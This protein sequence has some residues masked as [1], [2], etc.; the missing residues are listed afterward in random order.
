MTATV[1]TALQG[2]S[3]PG[4]PRVYV[5]GS[6]ERRVTVYAQQVRALN[7]VYALQAC[8]RLTS[9]SRVAVV[10]AGAAGLMC[11]A[12]ALHSGAQVTLLEKCK[13][14][15]PLFRMA[16]PEKPV[17][18][19]LHPRVYDWPQPGWDKPRASLP[20]LDWRSGSVAEVAEQLLTGWNRIAQTFQTTLKSHIDVNKVRIA[21]STEHA[22]RLSWT[23]TESGRKRPGRGDF[24]IVVLAVGFG[25]ES[26]ERADERS[27]WE[28]DDIDSSAGFRE[29]IDAPKTWLVSGCGDGGLT[30]L[31][32]V[33][34]D[35]FVH[36]QMLAALLPSD[37]DERDALETRVREI[38]DDAR[39]Q[40]SGAAD[41]LTKAYGDV[42][43]E[44]VVSAMEANLRKDTTA[45]L[46]SP[47]GAY[48][49]PE[50]SALNRFLVR[51]LY[52][53]GGFDEEPGLIKSVTD[54]PGGRVQVLFESGI[55][56][57][58][59]RIVRR[60]GPSPALKAFPQ[61]WDALESR[62]KEWQNSPQLLDQTRHR[63]WPEE[64]F[65]VEE[66]APRPV[67]RTVADD[68]DADKADS[69]SLRAPSARDAP[70][71]PETADPHDETR[72]KLAQAQT[73]KRRL[74][75]LG[76]STDEVVAEILRLKR[77][78]RPGGR[79]APGYVLGERYVLLRKIGRGGF[80]TVWEAEDTMSGERVAVKVLHSELAGDHLRR[81]RFFRGARL[82]AELA[83]EAVVQIVEAH[84]EDDGDCYY[85]MELLPDGNLATAV[86]AGRLERADIVPKLLQVGE[87]LAEAHRRGYIHR[88]VKPANILLS[89][90]GSLKLTDF[91]LV[92]AADTT[93]GTRTGA[94]GTFLFAAPEQLDR[95][96]A[97]DAS[98]DVYGLAMTAMFMLYGQKLPMTVMR[99]PG[100]IVEGL[101]CDARLKQVLMRALDWNRKERYQNAQAFCDAV[102]AAVTEHTALREVAPMRFIAIPAGVF[103]MGSPENEAGRRSNEGPQR[104]VQISSF[105]LAEHAVTQRQWQHV[106]GANPSDGD[107]GV[108]DALPVQNISW[109]D[110]VRFM[111]ALS[112][113]EGLRPCYEIEGTEVVWHRDRDGYRLP[114]EAEWEY[115][116][117]AGTQTAYSFGDDP[118]ELDK[119]AWYSENADDVVHEVGTKR[120]N[121]WNLY[122]MHGNVW[123]WVWDGYHERYPSEEHL[124]TV[125]PAEGDR[126]VL[127][128]GS[129]WDRP[130]DVRSAIRNRDWP[131]IRLEVI[132]LRVAGG[133]APQ[134][135]G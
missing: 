62:R 27:Y 69:A 49:R 91:D 70:P 29:G 37:S 36:E 59:D 101:D 122:D 109:Y 61:V 39:A 25:L 1:D 79:V 78:L 31:L 106:M 81:D 50:A 112:R 124:A 26:Y 123:E 134:H 67:S 60:H 32:R 9:G 72:A 94:L 4:F 92:A 54:A 13:H 15:L 115:A 89:E 86:L 16:D 20:L 51:Q 57:S 83:H 66:R 63:I 68:K 24:D 87:A 105:M 30:D 34:L 128:G 103:T 118:S 119:Y 104:E 38:E 88:D 135:D 52:A 45:V 116:C 95:P 11:A 73:R 126:R 14:V 97:V 23:K 77:S 111:N 107:Y 48:L 35:G 7:L 21:K 56:E 8:K 58:Y 47:D 64:T 125:V 41:F 96:Q 84:G 2:M 90:S 127:R 53:A 71:R 18:R 130:E 93:G 82:M 75:A 121:S 131:E 44:A 3:V 12:G 133:R 108:G 65:G 120:P 40:G 6:L 102:H 113:Q 46:N 132:G 76:A 99:N 10:G 117:R 110:A 42:R 100:E 5:L 43:V 33:R 98:A 28:P 85:A 22:V 19:W 17:N 114:T 55:D 129:F 80:A 74:E